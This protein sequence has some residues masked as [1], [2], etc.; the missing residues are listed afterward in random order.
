MIK[1]TTILINIFI[2]LLLNTGVILSQS[3]NP[4]VI[5][6]NGTTGQPGS[7]D[8]L[9]LIII[10]NGMQTLSELP[11]FSN[12]LSINNI[13][14][15][16][17]LPVLFQVKFRGATYNKMVPPAPMFRTKPVEIIVYDTVNDLSGL[18]IKNVVQISREENS[19][20]FIK[21]YIFN[22]LTNPKK[23]YVL[24]KPLEIFIPEQANEVKGQYTQSDS[25]MGI[26]LSLEKGEVGRKFDRAILP[27]QSE[28]F[29]SY[30]IPSNKN[31]ITT[32]EDRILFEKEEG[33]VFLLNPPDIKIKGRDLSPPTV[34]S[35]SGPDGM[36]GIRLNYK[37]KIAILEIIGGN[38]QREDTPQE[39]KVVNG[40]IFVNWINSTYG[41]LAILCLLI[42]L[43]YIFV[44]KK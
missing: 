5:I 32:L 15:P 38:P 10:S 27:G 26:P 1:S 8:G 37:N 44:Y 42:S 18:D 36:M 4:E 20:R 23:S 13:S 31:E 41:V 28:L 12:K 22:N 7:V 6:K 14:L 2:F 39:R 35:E 25:K 24:T 40:K 17:D 43:S 33:R 34:I 11:G 3:W 21:V 9:K 30:T 19:L 29:I 16:D